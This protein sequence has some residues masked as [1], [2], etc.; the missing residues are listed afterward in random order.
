[1]QNIKWTL[2]TLFGQYGQNNAEKYLPGL[3]GAKSNVAHLRSRG[4]NF[5]KSYFYQLHALQM[6]V[7]Y[8]CMN[9][10]GETTI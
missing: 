2:K 7:G 6:T 5:V 9:H 10:D 1:M 8:K 3:A 4:D